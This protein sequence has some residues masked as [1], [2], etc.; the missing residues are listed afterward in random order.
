MNAVTCEK[1][2]PLVALQ[3]VCACGQRLVQHAPEVQAEA[4][5]EQAAE[6]W[7]QERHRHRDFSQRGGAETVLVVPWR[8]T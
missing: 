3:G 1:W 6:G 8:L 4:L 7:H 5:R 2:R